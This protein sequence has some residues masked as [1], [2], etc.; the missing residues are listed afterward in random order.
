MRQTEFWE[1]VPLEERSLM[2]SGLA[3]R[4]LSWGAGSVTLYLAQAHRQYP[5]KSF[6][7]VLGEDEGKVS[8]VH[9]DPE[10]M[11]DRFAKAHCRKHNALEKL[12]SFESK[13]E[14]TCTA[15]LART[16]IVL[17]EQSH[18]SLRRTTMRG[19]QKMEK[20]FVAMQR[21]RFLG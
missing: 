3:F 17:V 13:L 5:F 4:L 21:R 2:T 15:V 12:K 16:D 19:L 6:L 7:G 11:R 20:I 18:S 10:C 1:S 14:L 8:G 9:H